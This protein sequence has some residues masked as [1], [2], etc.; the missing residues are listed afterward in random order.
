[1]KMGC[2][3]A[4]CGIGECSSFYV[5]NGVR[6]CLR[7]FRASTSIQGQRLG[8]TT[9]E[10]LQRLQSLKRKI[11]LLNLQGRVDCLMETAREIYAS[12]YW[13]DSRASLL[14]R[15]Q[16]LK[17]IVNWMYKAGMLRDENHYLGTRFTVANWVEE[18][19][20]LC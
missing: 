18:L 17:K 10:I 14:K 20:G 9:E 1:M 4:H 12:G 16:N 11:E 3:C 13:D 15:V 5:E 6:K 8:N 7:G 2:D 19:R